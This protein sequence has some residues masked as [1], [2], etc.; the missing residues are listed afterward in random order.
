MTTV[1]KKIIGTMWSKVFRS[2]DGDVLSH[3][4]AQTVTDYQLKMVIFFN[5]VFFDH[6]E[7][8]MAGRF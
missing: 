6:L 1:R 5:N 8:E 3:R 2:R 4:F 7:T